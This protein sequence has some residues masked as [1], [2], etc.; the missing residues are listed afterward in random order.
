MNKYKISIGC[1]LRFIL[2]NSEKFPFYFGCVTLRQSTKQRLRKREHQKTRKEK[3]EKKTKNK[4]KPKKR[5]KTKTLFIYQ[6]ASSLFFSSLFLLL[7]S[8]STV[9]V[10]RSVCTHVNRNMDPEHTDSVSM[11]SHENG[12][13]TEY[14]RRPKSILK[15]RDGSTVPITPLE[16]SARAKFDRRVSFAE[17]VKLHQIEL[18]HILQPAWPEADVEE[19]DSSD[20][21]TSFLNLEA[22]AD[23]IVS[24]LAPLIVPELSSSDESDV[25]D[26]NGD[27]E[28]TMD[29]TGQ[30]SISARTFGTE[31]RTELGVPRTDL[32]NGIG[33]NG[34]AHGIK[35]AE[36][37]AP[38]A[39]SESER[40]DDE[41]DMEL[42]EP[43][44]AGMVSEQEGSSGEKASLP[45]KESSEQKQEISEKTESGSEQ[46][47]SGSD[48]VDGGILLQSME[49][50]TAEP[51][52][53]EESGED[54][55]MDVTRHFSARAPKSSSPIQIPALEPLTD[56]DLD[57][58]V[59]MELTQ[60][61]SVRRE[62]NE[63]NGERVENSERAERVENVEIEEEV[64]ME[65]TQAL[66]PGLSGQN[67]LDVEKG[68]EKDEEKEI[69]EKGELSSDG[70]NANDVP[71]GLD[72]HTQPSSLLDNYTDHAH[73]AAGRPEELAPRNEKRPVPGARPVSAALHLPKRLH[74]EYVTSTTT[75]PLADVLMRSDDMPLEDTP[76]VSLTQ[77]LSDIGI[78]F[79]D[80]LEFSTDMSSRYRLSLSDAHTSARSEDYF[81]ANV[82]LPVLEVYE[83]CCKEL[84]EKIQQGM[85]LFESLKDETL[86]NN[87]E[88][89]R[90]YYQA[91]FYD[92]MTMKA[93]FHTLKEYTRQQAK[94]IWY[95][96][97]SKLIE[98]LLEVLNGNLEVLLSDKA[99]LVEQQSVLDSVFREIQQKYHSVRLDLLH[100]KDIQARY[101]DLDADQI[102]SIKLRLAELNQQLID[103]KNDIAQN[104]SQ[105]ERLQATIDHQ[106]NSV[107]ALTAQIAE[108]NNSLSKSRHFNT[109]EI[110]ALHMESQV[111]Q[112]G[113]GLKFVRVVERNIFEFQFNPRIM[114]TVDFRAP[115]NPQGIRFLLL[116]DD[117]VEVLHNEHL[118]VTCC[119]R[120]AEQ[121]GFTNIFDTFISFRRKW[122]KLTHIDKDI[123]HLSV[124]YPIRFE[125]G[126]ADVIAFTFTYYSFESK[127][128]A[129][130]RVR[131]ALDTILEYPGNVE[132]E[133]LLLRQADDVKLRVTG[134]SY[135]LFRQLV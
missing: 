48:T 71:E 108:S 102:Q 128:K 83:L 129:Q 101:E 92:Q 81:R 97:R 36:E 124:R 7:F 30:A 78:K 103:H 16:P 56:S 64:E 17:K 32:E 112:A 57:A 2:K 87:P 11:A 26:D 66:G 54:V 127:I 132:L 4:K 27:E 69:P 40:L 95:Q 70:N 85:R 100:F 19:E 93:R 43:I 44:K 25:D 106:K 72:A 53:P 77:F 126:D 20:D 55:S 73:S 21:D 88:L 119:Q 42:T 107:S 130:C 110:S 75:I 116:Q 90:T 34:L 52:N 99:V 84:S 47:E 79:Y 13:V 51:R 5:E 123:Y 115:E 133:I 8:S 91:S 135:G 117:P 28:Q 60:Q 61:L 6:T 14:G 49:A 121:T 118:L 23:K 113:A 105:L 62:E 35:E 50:H 65:L 86:Q 109:A 96:W 15:L 18:V 125:S 39:D 63:E 131:I 80:D 9:V 3:K 122:L 46:K 12:N 41:Q 33:P 104:E 94:Q 29:L 114:V 74:T 38:E 111:L 98:N 120:L 58:D 45:E 134:G 68:E 67:S 89:F 31:Q 24:A 22:D 76:N 10:R 1:N 59:P 82:Q 37:M